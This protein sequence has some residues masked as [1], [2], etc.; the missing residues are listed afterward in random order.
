MAG[1]ILL[2]CA[3]LLVCGVSFALFRDTIS[4]KEFCLQL[5]VSVAVAVSGWMF[6]RWHSMQSIEHWNGRITEKDSGTEGCCHCSTVCDARDKD[7]NCTS[8]HTECDHVLD[9]WWSVHVSTG[10]VITDG[11]HG[12]S[13]DPDW[14]T[15]AKVGE[16][17]SVP[18][19]YTN[20]LKADPE[21]IPH[22]TANPRD[23]AEVPPFPQVRDRYR[24]SKVVTHG[25]VRAPKN[26]QDELLNLN[27]D[28]G[29]RKQVD[30][31]VFL[32]KRPDAEFAYA[33]E[34]AWLYGPKNALI[35]VMGTDGKSITWARVVTIS[36]V[37]EL[38]ITLRDELPGRTLDD[39]DLI[40]FIGEQVKS[41]FHR[42]PMSK[43]EY[44]A[45]AAAPEGW[46]LVT[47]YL[48]V[49][50]VSVGLTM[51]MHA[52]DVFGDERFARFHRNRRRY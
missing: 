36:E 25:G 22:H 15:K 31:V 1:I 4:V 48:F 47:L 43:Y 11:C 35:V 24:V 7:G 51:Y 13:F 26:W 52:N 29:G 17:A 39:P 46:R 5:G 27:A 20:Y 41:K 33:I 32:T 6:T 38:A 30:V 49:I 42:T 23:L 18:H 9:Y 12:S 14:W 40:K 28:I 44:L 34:A 2:L 3:P 10:D 8:S 37:D 21:S 50:I 16:P 45:S 19:T